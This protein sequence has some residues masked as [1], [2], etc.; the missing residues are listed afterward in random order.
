MRAAP[1]SIPTVSNNRIR[2]AFIRATLLN[3]SEPIEMI[4]MCNHS[5]FFR[6]A[7]GT[8]PF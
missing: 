5:D 7:G 4:A 1:A 6:L 8:M 3:S 2:E